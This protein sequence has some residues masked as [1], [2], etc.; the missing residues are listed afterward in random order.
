MLSGINT[1]RPWLCFGLRLWFRDS[2]TQDGVRGYCW[3][4]VVLDPELKY[5]KDAA[6]LILQLAM[7][8]RSAKCHC[9]NALMRN[10][11]DR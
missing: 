8:R 11:C 10:I 4:D 1:P 5:G 6:R 2:K 3:A 9:Y 7:R